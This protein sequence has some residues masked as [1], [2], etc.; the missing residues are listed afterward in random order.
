M[1]QTLLA[2]GAEISSLIGVTRDSLLVTQ[3]QQRENRDRSLKSCY[4]PL[5][6]CGSL[7]LWVVITLNYGEHFDL[8]LL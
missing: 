2:L 4:K 1:V 8:E 5:L 3:Q 6:V 7:S